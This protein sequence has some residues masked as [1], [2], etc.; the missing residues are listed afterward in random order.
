MNPYNTYYVNQAGSGISVY[1]GSRYQRGHGLF[2]KLFSSAILPALKFLGKQA[3]GTGVNVAQD[4]LHGENFKKSVI[5]RAKQSG[6]NTAS[7]AIA[8]TNKFIQTGKGRKNKKRICKKTK[9]GK[10]KRLE[11]S[12]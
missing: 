8:R 4:V 2:G 3:L 6:R 1:S 7:S 10:L 9:R 11:L 5:R 12:L